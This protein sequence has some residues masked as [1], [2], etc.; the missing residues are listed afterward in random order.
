MELP[1]LIPV[2]TL[3]A[4]RES[5]YLPLLKSQRYAL[6]AASG[7]DSQ[8]VM[9][10]LFASAVVEKFQARVLN[11][12]NRGSKKRSDEE[13]T[14]AQG[15][16]TS[17]A[18]FDQLCAEYCQA[19]TCLID[20][21][22]ES[23]AHLFHVG[24][25]SLATHLDK[26]GEMPQANADRDSLFRQLAKQEGRELDK[27]EQYDASVLILD[28][29]AEGH[30]QGVTLS[31]DI[32][33]KLGIVCS[34]NHA[35]LTS[36]G[37]AGTA[38]IEQFFMIRWHDSLT[39][40]NQNLFEVLSRGDFQQ[41]AKL[42]GRSEEG[43]TQHEVLSWLEE[44][45]GFA[46]LLAA[47]YVMAQGSMYGALVLECKR[48]G[49]RLNDVAD[50]KQ[51]LYHAFQ[52]KHKKNPPWL[53]VPSTTRQIADHLQTISRQS[54]SVRGR[55]LKLIRLIDHK[56]NPCLALPLLNTGLVRDLQQQFFKAADKPDPRLWRKL[57]CEIALGGSKPQNAGTFFTSFMHMGKA[58]SLLCDVPLQ[59]GGMRLIKLRLAKGQNLYYL[60]RDTALNICS[61][62]P[63][64]G[65]HWL[66][67]PLS[68]KGKGALRE[69]LKRWLLSVQAHHASIA[70]QVNAG[71]IS[72]LYFK[73]QHRVDYIR[74][75][76]RMILGC[77]DEQDV[78][79]YTRHL[80]LQLLS[81]TVL[82]LA[83]RKYVIRTMRLLAAEIMEV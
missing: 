67:R 39:G 63:Q 26:S 36:V 11:S 32:Q 40:R 76:H 70:S 65:T 54:N 64:Q 9:R 1:L 23:A 82:T 18:L 7:E 69:R 6:E 31:S 53:F 73:T 75:E 2:S 3:F 62:P 30:P 10:F 49:E 17:W 37:N 38:T 33:A 12:V 15:V 16:Q 66:S 5:S 57:F 50:E 21:N 43:I 46:T 79:T 19:D 60:N 59:Q 52:A 25:K 71:M 74:A 34:S 56:Q 58:K 13:L 41:M 77:A 28:P 8:R 72:P 48:L 55:G 68:Q 29:F 81:K 61:R 14:N 24:F 78:L 45:T 80:A 47:L 22:L 44:S 35:M 83:E 4:D 42:A 20:A 27:I 51:S